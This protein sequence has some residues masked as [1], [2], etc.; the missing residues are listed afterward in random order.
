[1][2]NTKDFIFFTDP[3]NTKVKKGEKSISTQS[4]DKHFRKRFDWVGIY[5]ASTHSFRLTRLHVYEGLCLREIMDI[6]GHRRIVSVQQYRDTDKNQTFNKHR[7]RL[8][9]EDA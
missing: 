4:I 3:R 9:K 8:Q 7:D 1:M 5:G 6:S 2:L